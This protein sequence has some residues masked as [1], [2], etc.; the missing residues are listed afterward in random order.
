MAEFL[1]SKSFSFSMA[2]TLQWLSWKGGAVLEMNW[3]DPGTY[4][5]NVT[6]L[7]LGLVVLACLGAVV[8][9]IIQDLNAKRKLRREMKH[10]DGELRDLVSSYDGHTFNVPGLGLTMADGGEP[11]DGKQPERKRDE[12]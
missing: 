2:S 12:R 6:N 3:N 4:W 7:G 8:I 9:G 10:I 11:L 1:T 5:L